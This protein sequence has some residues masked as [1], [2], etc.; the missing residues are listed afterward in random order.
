MQVCW[1]VSDK[2]YY[3]DENF[4]ATIVWKF[5]QSFLVNDEK[6]WIVS[7]QNAASSADQWSDIDKIFTFSVYNIIIIIC[8]MLHMSAAITNQGQS[9]WQNAYEQ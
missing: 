6:L 4:L 3:Q 5:H 8:H 9:E 1:R 2:K 7:K